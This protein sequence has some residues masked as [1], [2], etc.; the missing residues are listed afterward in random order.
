MF[1]ESLLCAET[2]VSVGA[3]RYDAGTNPP[4]SLSMQQFRAY[5]DE[6]LPIFGIQSVHFAVRSRSLRKVLYGAESAS[7]TFVDSFEPVMVYIL[8][9]TEAS[10]KQTVGP[11]A[12]LVSYSVRV[13]GT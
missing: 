8:P 11:S 3:H 1:Q 12:R 10:F 6:K 5:L 9:G 2:L 4:P 7:T 13:E